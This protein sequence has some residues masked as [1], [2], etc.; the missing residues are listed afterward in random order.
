VLSHRTE[1][2]D[3]RL[4]RIEDAVFRNLELGGQAKATLSRHRREA[5]SDDS[6]HIADEE[7]WDPRVLPPA[8]P[9]APAPTPVTPRPEPVALAQPQS[10]RFEGV[11]KI[12]APSAPVGSCVFIGAS[13]PFSFVSR[14]GVRWIDAK[15]GNNSFSKLLQRAEEKYLALDA[16]GVFGS[17]LSGQA[18]VEFVET[19]EL[20][21]LYIN[22]IYPATGV[23]R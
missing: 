13:S 5:S 23:P 14:T 12:T 20:R 3:E 2:L 22:G 19:P 16:E 9:V 11:L 21:E 17:G 8:N 6:D 15:L 7:L 10:P 1:D 18:A 4:R